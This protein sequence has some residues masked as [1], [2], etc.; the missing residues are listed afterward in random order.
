MISCKNVGYISKGYE[1]QLVHKKSVRPKFNI[2]TMFS[3]DIMKMPKIIPIP[4]NII[5]IRKYTMKTDNIVNIE[6]GLTK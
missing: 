2:P 4:L 6:I 1:I 5:E 3:F